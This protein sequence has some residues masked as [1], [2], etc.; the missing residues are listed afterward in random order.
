MNKFKVIDAQYVE[1]YKLKI[2]FADN[3][4]VIVEF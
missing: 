2:T 1:G 3:H 4:C